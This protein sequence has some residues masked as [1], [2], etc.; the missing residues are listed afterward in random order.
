MINDAGKHKVKTPALAVTLS[1][2]EDAL[3]RP[4][5]LSALAPARGEVLGVGGNDCAKGTALP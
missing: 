2:G 1:S 5:I 3:S 4:R